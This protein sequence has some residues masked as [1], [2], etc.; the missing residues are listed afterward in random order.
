MQVLLKISN[1]YYFCYTCRRQWKNFFGRKHHKFH[2]MFKSNKNLW[3]P[4]IASNSLETMMKI[5]F[6]SQYENTHN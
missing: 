5:C 1:L 4:T 6:I 2:E 3:T